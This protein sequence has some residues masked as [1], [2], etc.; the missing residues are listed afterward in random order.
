MKGLQRSGKLKRYTSEKIFPAAWAV[1]I[2][3]PLLS[4]AKNTIFVSFTAFSQQKLL[5][6]T[7]FTQLAAVITH[8]R[9][10][11]TFVL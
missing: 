10:R 8:L 1:R 2:L 7:V 11:K 9:A 4:R 5:G 3:S 6:I